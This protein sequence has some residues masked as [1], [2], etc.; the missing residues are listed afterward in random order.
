MDMRFIGYTIGRTKNTFKFIGH[1]DHKIQETI[2]QNTTSQ[3]IIALYMLFTFIEMERKSNSGESREGVLIQKGPGSHGRP[4]W[5][6]K[7]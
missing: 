5:S 3:S 1:P 7:L 4:P 2:T 6:L